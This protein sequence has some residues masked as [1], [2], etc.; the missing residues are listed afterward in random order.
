MGW[1]TV[2]EKAGER[3]R[4]SVLLTGNNGQQISAQVSL[5]PHE[6]GLIQLE[7]R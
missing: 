1:Q 5:G 7:P 2:R 6:A 3:E 4:R